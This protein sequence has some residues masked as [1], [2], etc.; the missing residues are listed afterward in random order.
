METIRIGVAP[1]GQMKPKCLLKPD[2]YCR[3]GVELEIL[4]LL[5][6]SLNF[7]AIINITS[8]KDRG[9]GSLV[10]GTWTGLS[11]LLINNQIDII[12][13]LCDLDEERE[14]H[15]GFSFPVWQYPQAYLMRAPE[16]EYS[17]NPSAPFQL[18]VWV[19]ALACIILWYLLMLVRHVI[20]LK[21]NF[22]TSASECGTNMVNYSV[23]FADPDEGKLYWIVWICFFGFLTI[24]YDTYIKTA[25][26]YTYPIQRPF[27]D[28]REFAEKM[29]EGTYLLLD[30]R[31]PAKEPSCVDNYTCSTFKKAIDEGNYFY[32]R[33]GDGID[34][35]NLLA[36]DDRLV[37]PKGKIFLDTYLSD[38]PNRELFWLFE[39]DAMSGKRSVFLWRKEFY[40]RQHFDLVLM[41]MSDFKMSVRS[42]YVRMYG[43]QPKSNQYIK[44]EVID[45]DSLG[46]SRLQGPFYLYLF[47]IAVSLFVFVIETL[48]RFSFVFT[49]MNK[50]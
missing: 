9:C 32:S 18:P 41:M 36:N 31:D 11:G 10:N 23:G 43:S 44:P 48:C 6:K 20:I 2:L 28:A 37:L 39:D 30:T 19:F 24:I 8:V 35:V 21:M 1:W 42:R 40:Y 29:L 4:D 33:S 38:F 45:K 17:F 49:G 25:L 12:G 50:I 5:I 27:N 13:N 34:M 46:L 22:K 7:S 14:E 26:L 15:F 16:P 3:P 47:L